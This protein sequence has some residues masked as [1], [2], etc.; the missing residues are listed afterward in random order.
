M[1]LCPVRDDVYRPAQ[2]VEMN[3]EMG[4]NVKLR[5][6]MSSAQRKRVG[7][8]GIRRQLAGLLGAKKPIPR[9]D[10]VRRCQLAFSIRTMTHMDEGVVVKC[11]SGTL[12]V[13]CGAH[14]R[15][16]ECLYPPRCKMRRII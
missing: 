9:R 14:V 7:E 16:D 5:V 8:Q 2:G 10:E 13:G 4:R 1:V 3:G 6:L 11:N 12:A 15:A